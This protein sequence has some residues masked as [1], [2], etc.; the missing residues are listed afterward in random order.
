MGDAFAIARLDARRVLNSHLEWTLE[1]GVELEDGRRGRGAAPRGE[2]PSIYE[3]ARDRVPLTAALDDARRSLM[4]RSLCQETLDALLLEHQAAWG[5]AAAYA[6]SVA[7]YEAT[8]TSGVTSGDGTARRPRILFNLLNGGMHAYTNP[9]ASDFTELLLVPRDEDVSATID[10]Y[11]RLLDAASTRLSRMPSRLVGGNR[12]ADLGARP[13]EGACSLVRELLDDTGLTGQFGVMVDASAGDWVRDDVY[14]LPVSGRRMGTAA[15][16]DY[17]LELIDRH[18]LEFVE[19]PFGELDVVGWEALHRARPSRALILGDN[20]T[21]SDVT[22]LDARPDLLDGVLLKPDQAGTVTRAMQFGQ[23]ARQLG[24]QL[25]ASH[26]S[27]E[28]DST[29]LV[30]LAGRLQSDWI[31]IGPFSDFSSVMRTNELLRSSA[32]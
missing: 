11:R 32:R 13:N 15:L 25:I 10:A 28:T 9:I 20:F 30:H 31:K 8:W 26:R 21:S 7:C 2:T 22:H 12:V 6:V 16:V 29:F 27:I 1:F 19:D 23:R 17:W 24:L 4:G 3:R 18:G 14:E 5:A